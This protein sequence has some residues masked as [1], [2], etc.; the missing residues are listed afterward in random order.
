MFADEA[1]VASNLQKHTHDDDHRLWGVQGR[2][3][4]DNSLN[5]FESGRV[6]KAYEGGESEEECRCFV[7][8]HKR[9]DAS[10]DQGGGMAA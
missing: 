1:M 6:M 7:R 2:G 3:R 9:G 5:Y 8:S 4:L 10:S